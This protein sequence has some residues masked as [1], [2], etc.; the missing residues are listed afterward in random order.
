MFATS[1]IVRTAPRSENRRRLRL[2]PQD[3][4]LPRGNDYLVTVHSL[5][6]KKL[7]CPHARRQFCGL[8][9]LA[10]IERDEAAIAV[11]PTLIRVQSAVVVD[12]KRTKRSGSQ[13]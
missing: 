6:R 2:D 1:S 8:R 3:D 12:Y 11:G 13:G 5:T 9:C 10:A 7:G 4:R